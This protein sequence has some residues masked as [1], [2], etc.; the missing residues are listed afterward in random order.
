MGRI[1]ECLFATDSIPRRV[2]YCSNVGDSLGVL[3]RDGKVVKLSYPHNTRDPNEAGRIRLAG[4]TVNEGRL[5]GYGLNVSRSLGDRYVG[6]Y[7]IADPYTTE[8]ELCDQDEFVI[9][10]SD[11][12]WDF[13]KDFQVAI[14]HVRYTRDPK[15]AAEEL[16]K[17]AI[18]SESPDDITVVV[19]RFRDPPTSH[20]SIFGRVFKPWVA[21]LGL[22]SVKS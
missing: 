3:C 21:S 15:K 10:A 5:A 4:G 1:R 2:L 8:T 18:D 7:L 20:K 16:I 11:G 12:L 6:E 22:R 19:I 9:L 13:V 17:L 14:N